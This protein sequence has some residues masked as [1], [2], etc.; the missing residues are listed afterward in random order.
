MER[1]PLHYKNA[2]KVQKKS[3]IYKLSFYGEKIDGNK[4]TVIL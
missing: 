1:F 2:T 3:D 4:P